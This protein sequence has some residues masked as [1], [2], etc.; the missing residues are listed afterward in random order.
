MLSEARQYLSIAPWIAV[1]PGVFITVTVISVTVTGR[2][3]QQRFV[4]K[5]SSL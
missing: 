1:W 3:L 4:S 5:R 2:Y